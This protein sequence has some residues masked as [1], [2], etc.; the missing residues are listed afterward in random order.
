MFKDAGIIVI[1]ATISPLIELRELAKEIIGEKN[2]IPFYIKA[3][4][5]ACKKRDPKGLYK[6]YFNSQNTMEYEEDKNSLEI[7]TEKLSVD[8]AVDFIIKIMEDKNNGS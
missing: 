2:Y 3:S 8:E 7:D 6:N 1:V 5:E 4:L